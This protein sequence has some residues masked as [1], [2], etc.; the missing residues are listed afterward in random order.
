MDPDCDAVKND[1]LVVMAIIQEI[2]NPLQEKRRNI[3][4]NILK[5]MEYEKLT[6]ET[7]FAYQ[8]EKERKKQY[9]RRLQRVRKKT[10]LSC[11]T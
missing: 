11:P 7:K 10:V 4:K 3:R 5:V 8:Q 6:P 9:V 2:E 1:D